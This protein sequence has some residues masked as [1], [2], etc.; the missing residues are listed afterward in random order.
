[1]PINDIERL[2]TAVVVCNFE[3]MGIQSKLTIVFDT[4]CLMCSAWVGFI[5]RHEREAS[6]RFL[7]AWSE[8]G[9]ALANQFNL[10]PQDLDKTYLVV[11]DGQPLTKSDATFA[12]FRTLRAPWRWAG[13]LHFLPR[14]VRD[15]FYDVIAKNRYRW[16]GQKDQC[17]L[18]PEG[19]QARFVLGPPRSAVL[20]DHR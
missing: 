6:A 1:M 18:P 17:F 16:F 20:P 2:G 7:S 9:L 13:A 3:H 10:A 15:R 19:Q 11:A 4:D 14:S 8:D 5:L 12:I